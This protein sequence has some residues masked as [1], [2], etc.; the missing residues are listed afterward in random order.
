MR[1]ALAAATALVTALAL[2]FGGLLRPSQ[3]APAPT[4]APARVADAALSGF[5]SFSTQRLVDDLQQRVEANPGDARSLAT[6][7]LAYQQRVRESGDPAFYALAE[8]ALARAHALEPEDP[9]ALTGL[10]TLALARHRFGDALVLARTT[11]RLAPDIVCTYGALGDALVELGRYREA[12]AAFDRMAELKPSLAAYARVSYARELLGDR[13]GA[14]AAMQLALDAAG[15]APEP[16]AWT[17][18]QLA[19]LDGNGGDLRRAYGEYAAALRFKPG[20]PA[21]LDGLARIEAARGKLGPAIAHARR[22]ADAAPLPEYVGHLHDLLRAAGRDD[23]AAR[24]LK[25]LRGVERLL[26]ANGVRTELE[27]ALFDLDHGY[28]LP[29]ALALART[30]HR[31]RPSIDGDDGLAWALQRNGRCGEALRWSKRSLRLG[32]QDAAKFFHRGMIERCLGRDGGPWFRRAV[33]L[34]PHF[35]TVWSPLARRLA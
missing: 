22:A 29:Q 13:T 23:L 34:N 5:A 25:V 6:L 27:T 24:Q 3:S 32:T 4:V 16:T 31:L 18:V 10:T 17:L 33:A 20:Y 21:A 19:K 1:I 11:R 28:R 35:S 7:G 15:G 12:F 30:A 2:L 26:V 9:V 14:R 8:T